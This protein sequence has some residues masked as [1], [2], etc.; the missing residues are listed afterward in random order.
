MTTAALDVTHLR[1]QQVQRS[2]EKD[3]ISVIGNIAVARHIS[4]ALMDS[5]GVDSPRRST[6]VDDPRRLWSAKAVGV[7]VSHD[8][9]AALLLLFSG[10]LELP[11]LDLRSSLE[12]ANGF[13]G[14]VEAEISLSF[15]KMNPEL[16]PC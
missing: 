13:T 8:I 7:D 15:G 9:V 14:D 4:Q 1:Q 6:P 5:D 16:A 10:N 3:Q 2:P 11:I 12:L